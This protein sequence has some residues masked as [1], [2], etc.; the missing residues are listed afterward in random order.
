MWCC[1]VRL[2]GV[3]YGIAQTFFG[4]LERSAGRCQYLSLMR[5]THSLQGG[6]FWKESSGAKQ[7]VV[8]D[9]VE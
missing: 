2:T 5:W 3:Q 4:S 7:R 9:K 1:V 8:F 6:K